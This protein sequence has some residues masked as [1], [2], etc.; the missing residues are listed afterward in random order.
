M[1]DITDGVKK[2]L[3]N[4]R[5]VTAAI[6]ATTATTA[7]VATAAAAA[8]AASAVATTA[9]DSGLLLDIACVWYAVRRSPHAH[10]EP[11]AKWESLE[12]SFQGGVI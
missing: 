1:P 5:A 9:M 6:A 3:G 10:K 12:R 2:L 8:A 4:T 11:W 7:V